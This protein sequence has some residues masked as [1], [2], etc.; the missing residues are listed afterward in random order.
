MSS[1]QNKRPSLK[2]EY[3]AT[4]IRVANQSRQ[5]D[6]E[7][8]AYWVQCAYGDD[9]AARVSTMP[10]NLLEELYPELV[11]F[12]PAVKEIEALLSAVERVSDDEYDMDALSGFAQIFKYG[13]G[14][15]K[16]A[17]DHMQAALDESWKLSQSYLAVQTE[18]RRKYR[19]PVSVTAA[20]GFLSVM[21]NTQY[22]QN[23]GTRESFTPYVI[24]VNEMLAML[25]LPPLSGLY[26]NTSD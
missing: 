13:T 12:G 17:N 25:E 22:V 15:L 8:L 2:G 18:A 19:F 21:L 26:G 4:V 23:D 16:P 14:G 24:M 3:L 1:R 11:S 20:V 7:S 9:E 5:L 6:S 10:E